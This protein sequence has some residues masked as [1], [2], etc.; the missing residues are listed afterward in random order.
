[1]ERKLTVI[2]SADV[3]G[4]GRLMGEDEEATV[5]TLTEYREVMGGLIQRHRGHV[6]DSPGDN[7]LAQFASAVDAVYCAVDIQKD[8][9]RRN[10]A[11]VEDRRMHFRIGLN[12]GDVIVEGERIYGDGV[13]V[14][15]RV[16]GLAGGGGIYITG[17]VYDHVV[18]KLSF[19]FH[20]LGEKTVKNIADPVR[21][22][23]VRW[24]TEATSAGK[25]KPSRQW[26]WKTVSVVV[27]AAVAFFFWR[28]VYEERKSLPP[29]DKPSIAILPFADISPQ[30]DQEYFS[31]G[32]TEELTSKLSRFQNLR[33]SARTSVLRFKGTQKDIK[34]I[35]EELAVRYILEGSVRKAGNRVR[36]TAQLIDASTG[37]HLW[38]NDFDEELKDVFAV[39]EETA[40]EIVAALNLHLS[41]RE[42]ETVRRRYTENIQAYDAYLRGWTLVESFHVNVDVSKDT[43]EAARKHFE[44]ALASDPNYPLALAGLSIVESSFYQFNVDRS[45]D[46]LQNAEELA[47]RA[48]ALDP[49][50]AESHLALADAYL[51]GGNFPLAIDGY[52]KGLSLDPNNAYGWCHFAAAC[53]SKNPPDPEEAEKASQK[54]IHLFPDYFWPHAV[55]GKALEMQS[56]YEESIAAYEYALQLNPDFKGGHVRIGQIHLIQGKYNQALTQFNKAREIGESPSLLV[57]ISAAFAS[58]GETEKSVSELEKAFAGGYHN[59]AEIE[60]NPHFDSLHADPRFQEL[61]RQM[62][63]KPKV[64]HK[65]DS[66]GSG[67]I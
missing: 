61:L 34:T 48:L 31:D 25:G 12:L 30:R 51:V 37:F 11:Y 24:D 32:M 17:T 58:L 66:M 10:A 26:R 40:L 3:E 4:Y 41:P 27:V 7:L 45:R 65:A 1:M 50:L 5:R 16:E 19:A 63:M 42:A 14:A 20:D 67:C 18:N 47:R 21:V 28:Q 56:R 6:I 46:R 29:T 59:I 8:L 22:Y 55:L 35:G 15:A 13:N 39:Q 33:V 9:R 64:M 54:A 23:D 2:L 60:A 44:R 38:S 52:R 53:N 36:I 43:L 57:Q 49:Q 62:K